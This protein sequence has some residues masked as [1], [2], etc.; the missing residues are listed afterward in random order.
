MDSI[1]YD[2]QT[3]LIV[4]DVQNDFAD[5]EGSLS[6]SGGDAVVPLINDEIADAR[7]QGALVVYTQD[8]HPPDTPHFAKDGG[9]WPVHCVG[10]TWGAEFHPDL[11][12]DGPVVRKGVD[13]ARRLLGVHDPPPHHR[14]DRAHGAGRDPARRRH[15]D[16]DDHRARHRLLRAG[17][18]AGCAG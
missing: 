4:V 9:I 15:H 16:A 6:V 18:G 8:W 7:G 5:P 2:A 1:S 3:A 10:E 17:D 11:V 14:G 13:G 12:V